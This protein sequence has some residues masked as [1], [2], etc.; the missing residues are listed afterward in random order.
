MIVGTAKLSGLIRSEGLDLFIFSD[1]YPIIF[2]HRSNFSREDQ[3]T[4]TEA[5]PVTF[6]L[7][8]HPKGPCAIDVK[9]V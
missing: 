5:A 6:L 1:T 4:A 7:G 3:E 9:L 2:F 8:R